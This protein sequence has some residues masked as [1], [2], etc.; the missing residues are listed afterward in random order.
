MKGN[1]IVFSPTGGTE[2]VGKMLLS[3]FDLGD[4]IDIG[5]KNFTSYSCKEDEVYIVAIPAF[6][7]RIPEV[8]KESLSKIKANSAKAVALIAYG[9]RGIDDSL[10]ELGDLLDEIGFILT[11]GVIASTEHSIFRDFGTGRPDQQDEKELSEFS[12]KI[13]EKI[14]SE[15]I[16]RVKLPGDRP[17][18]D[19]IV[20]TITPLVDNSCILCGICADECPVGA[21]PK[22]RANTTEEDVCIACMRCIKVC[23]ENSRK[24]HEKV[25]E[26]GNIHMKEKLETRKKNKLYI[27]IKDEN[28]SSRR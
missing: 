2:K 4:I 3:S 8:C 14:L 15:K 26:I 5:D 21:I 9:N 17:Y 7:G 22:D 28:I 10:L 24:L 23:P 1:L 12:D 16:S 20:S 6:S 18:R 19:L 11:A 27:G 13:K 25:L